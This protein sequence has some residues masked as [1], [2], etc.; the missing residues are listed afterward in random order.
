MSVD[1]TGK[2]YCGLNITW[3]YTKKFVDISM[4]NYIPN[5]LKKFQHPTPKTLVCTPHQYTPPTY[6]SKTQHASEEDL[7]TPLNPKQ[8]KHT[9]AIIGSLLYY[10]RAVDPTILVALNELSAQQA[11]PTT[12]TLKKLNRLLDYVATFPHAIL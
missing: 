3:N 11:T 4:D 8:T 12:N 10:A 9:H 5:M 6:G 1:W 2:N 7:S